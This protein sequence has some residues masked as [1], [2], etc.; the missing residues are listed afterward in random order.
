MGVFDKL[1]EKKL[2]FVIAAVSL[3]VLLLGIAGGFSI[4][5]AMRYKAARAAVLPAGFTVT[6]HTGCNG[7][8]PNSI[9]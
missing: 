1:G 2:R 3:A 5:A 9:V 6:A 8:K 4:A 7:T